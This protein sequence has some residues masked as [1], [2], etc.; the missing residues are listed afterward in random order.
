MRGRSELAHHLAVEAIDDAIARQRDEFD[1]AF[2]ARLEAH[3][4]A[5]RDVET[6][7]A[8]RFAIERERRVHLVEVIVRADLHGTIARVRYRHADGGAS[9]IQFVLAVVGYQ[10]TW[11]HA[12]LVTESDDGRS[13]VS[14]H[15]GRW[16]RPGYRESSR[17]RRPSR[18][19][20]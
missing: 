9:C 20:A 7:A 13:R 15:R 1:G 11:D 14:C 4:G 18:R 10:F 5:R 8:R 6:K 12:R 2:L 3:G 16:L 17:A 19:R